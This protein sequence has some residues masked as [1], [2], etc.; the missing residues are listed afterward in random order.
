MNRLIDGFKHCPGEVHTGI[1]SSQF[2][3]ANNGSY[4]CFPIVKTEIVHLNAAFVTIMS[5][6][7]NQK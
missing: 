4:A 2:V 3:I 1:D 5:L 6:V 7:A